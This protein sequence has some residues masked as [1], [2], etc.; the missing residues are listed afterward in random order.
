MALKSKKRL[1][2]NTL[3]LQQCNKN[4]IK[5]TNFDA[6]GEVE[7]NLKFNFFKFS[8]VILKFSYRRNLVYFIIHFHFIMQPFLTFFDNYDA[9]F[10]KSIIFEALYFNV[11]A[12]LSIFVSEKD[13]CSSRCILQ[14]GKEFGCS[15]RDNFS[16][17]IWLTI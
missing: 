3:I 6:P 8:N 16:E 15:A 17:A 7:G 13:I 1:K 9:N 14:N 10:L 5:Q 4:A 2:R 11:I 12:Q